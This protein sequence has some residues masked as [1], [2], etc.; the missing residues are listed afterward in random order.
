M[1]GLSSLVGSWRLDVGHNGG[2]NGDTWGRD[3]C[4]ARVRV[5]SFDDSY[6]KKLKLYSSP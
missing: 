6:S 5:A 3:A 4:L 2:V 1:M